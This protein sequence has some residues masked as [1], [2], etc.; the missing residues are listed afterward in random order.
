MRVTVA[1]TQHTDACMNGTTTGAG[2][3]QFT[4]I[5]DTAVLTPSESGPSTKFKLESDTCN[6]T[7]DPSAGGNWATFS[8]AA[9][10]KASSFTVKAAN[11]GV[12]GNPATCI[13]ILTDASGQR[14]AI[15]VQ[16]TLG[17]V[18][19]NARHGRR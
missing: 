17:S 15:D 5:G 18:G 2:S 11:A 16:V 14:V 13:A 1:C 8:P 9:G 6:K 7:D 19:I 4:A 12:T 10:R 3:I